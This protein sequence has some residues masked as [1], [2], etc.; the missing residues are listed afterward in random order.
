MSKSVE[1]IVPWGRK[2]FPVDGSGVTLK[3]NPGDRLRFKPIDNEVHDVD[4]VVLDNCEGEECGLRWNRRA[5]QRRLNCNYRTRVADIKE[6]GVYHLVDPNN[7]DV[8]RLTV[9]ASNDRDMC[10][11]FDEAKRVDRERCRGATGIMPAIEPVDEA[12]SAT[13]ARFL[14]AAITS[15]TQPVNPFQDLFGTTAPAST[16]RSFNIFSR[17]FVI[18]PLGKVIDTST[19]AAA[20][21]LA[22]ATSPFTPS[23]PSPLQPATTGLG[24]VVPSPL[25]P[26]SPVVRGRQRTASDEIADILNGI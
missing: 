11:L 7:S 1:H 6:S 13:L 5:A 22:T 9:L 12:S 25:E 26:I 14:P 15:N 17:D 4:E 23:V 8:V 18:G 19:P 21:P 24:P 3:C 10:Q 20:A 16:G 2:A